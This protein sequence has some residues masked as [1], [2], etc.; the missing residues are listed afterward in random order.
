MPSEPIRKNPYHPDLAIFLVL[1]PFISAV[2][3]YLTYDDIRPNGFLLLT[4]TID[5]LQ[6][7]VAWWATRAFIFYLDKKLPY[8]EHLGRRLITQLVGTLVIGL[9]IISLLTELVSILARGKTAPAE[10]Y[11][12]DLFIIGIWFFVLNGVYLGI[13]FYK[14]YVEAETQRLHERK[15]K[16]DGLFVKQ[17]KQD[18]RVEHQ[19]LAGFFVDGEYTVACQTD[20]KKYYLNDSLDK[21][22]KTLP[23]EFFFRVSRQFIVHRQ[24]ATGFK[25]A[26]NGK[27]I[28]QLSQIASI[29][30]EVIVSRLRAPAFKGWFKAS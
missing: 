22:E 16:T 5:T 28:V 17:G 1:I 15:I 7:Y 26:E 9:T 12:F 8:R 20:G 18:I 29:P 19:T 14:R 10:F 21:I 25:R 6:G 11:L 13:Y 23:P 30:A 3:Y 4:F 27:I 24:I 2:N